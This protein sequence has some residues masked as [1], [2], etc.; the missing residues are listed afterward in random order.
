MINT[1]GGLKV[2]V[3]YG[4]EQKHSKKHIFMGK[5]G[6]A[7]RQPARLRCIEGGKEVP[8]RRWWY[9]PVLLSAVCPFQRVLQR[10][11]RL[12]AV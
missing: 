7:I 10:R 6:E 9:S 11:P 4:S 2:K 3:T 5:K 12:S 8:R 1:V